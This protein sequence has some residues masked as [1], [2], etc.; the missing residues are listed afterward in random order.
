MKQTPTNTYTSYA[1]YGGVPPIETVAIPNTNE[2][3]DK[4]KFVWRGSERNLQSLCNCGKTLTLGTSI[5]DRADTI[6]LDDCDP[7]TSDLSST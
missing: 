3:V 5:I 4:T 1:E 7:Y 6:L 2:N